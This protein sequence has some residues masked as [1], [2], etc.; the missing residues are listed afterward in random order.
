M[1]IKRIDASTVKI[2]TKTESFL[3]IEQSRG[4]YG[5]GKAIQLYHLN[6][7]KQEH[8]KE[9]GWTRDDGYKTAKKEP[10]FIEGITTWENAIEGAKKYLKEVYDITE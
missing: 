1:E 10:G 8:V 7:I 2:A 4:V 5:S 9:I 6:G 3:L